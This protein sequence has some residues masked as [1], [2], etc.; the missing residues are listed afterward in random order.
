MLNLHLQFDTNSSH[1]TPLHPPSHLT[2]NSTTTTSSSSSSSNQSRTVTQTSSHSHLF[3]WNRTQAHSVRANFTR[4]YQEP[5]EARE[6]SPG[7]GAA[8]P[9]CSSPSDLSL[10]SPSETV[11]HS[12]AE[13]K[14][15]ILFGSEPTSAACLNHSGETP[16]E[17]PGSQHHRLWTEAPISAMGDWPGS[18]L[19]GPAPCRTRAAETRSGVVTASL[20]GSLRGA[21]KCMEDEAETSSSSDDEGKLVIEFETN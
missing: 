17:A 19:N 8:P 5:G 6:S 1:G 7:T 9:P 16:S 3:A 21:R 12:E 2:S 18:Q 10:H 15:H 11:N 13:W 20:S 14:A 4:C